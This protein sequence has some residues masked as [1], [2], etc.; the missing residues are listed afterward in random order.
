MCCE[1]GGNGS[2]DWMQQLVCNGR[3]VCRLW[4]VRHGVGMQVSGNF[5]CCG[6]RDWRWW[7]HSGWR[8]DMLLGVTWIFN[9]TLDQAHQGTRLHW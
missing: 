5:G 6:V 8:N 1:V 9:D 2:A 7:V 4:H 3:Q